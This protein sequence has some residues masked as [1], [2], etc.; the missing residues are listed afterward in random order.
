MDRKTKRES[1]ELERETEKQR[2][3][4]RSINKK[5][6]K[7]KV[8]VDNTPSSLVSSHKKKKHEAE[9]EGL[10]S[11]SCHR[12]IQDHHAPSAVQSCHIPAPTAD[13]KPFTRYDG[14]GGNGSNK[15]GSHTLSIA[16]AGSI[17]NNVQSLEQAT[18]LAG[19]IARATAIFR[20]DE[21]II[22]FDDGTDSEVYFHRTGWACEIQ[23]K[24]G[25]QFLARILQYL[26]VPQYLRRTLFPMHP[27]FRFVGL[28]PPLD[29][30]HH[31]R[32]H[33]WL[34]YREGVTVDKKVES[35]EGSYVDVGLHKDVLIRHSKQPGVRVTVA[36]GP[37]RD[38]LDQNGVVL[39]AVTRTVPREKEG[40]YWGY[41]V[42][43]A[44]HLNA[45][46]KDCPFPGGYDYTIGTSEHGEKI[47][48]SEFIIPRTSRHV[49]VAFGGLAGLEESKDLDETINVNEV[50]CCFHRY[51]NTCPDQ[52]SRTIRTEEAIL[53]SLQ[54]LHDPILRAFEAAETLK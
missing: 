16:V 35:G 6:K 51:I 21:Q 20:V 13:S 10:A 7:K 4:T 28:L 2:L 23:E 26:E 11:L 53:I 3:K 36:M 37:S 1:K 52:G 48:A 39:D 38:V 15:G 12:L 18:R 34:P 22:V 24:T 47:R 30:P 27:S 8:K 43:H 32:K 9:E 40:L 31:L 14:N 54:Y 19:Q 5:K 49:L 29:V 50:A 44:A 25:G 33:G 17:I 42:R 46:F 45:V 41:S